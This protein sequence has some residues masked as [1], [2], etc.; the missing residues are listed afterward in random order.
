MIT[1]EN[2]P[3]C[4]EVGTLRWAVDPVFPDPFTERVDPLAPL[5]PKTFEH[6]QLPTYHCDKCGA[7]WIPGEH[8]Q[9][10]TESEDNQ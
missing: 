10:S 8:V 3:V 1:L 2:C 9:Y 6:V 4:H 7:V 5:V